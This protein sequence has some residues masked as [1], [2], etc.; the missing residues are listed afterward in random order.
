MI[1]T[2]FYPSVY[3][4][5]L[6]ESAP[7]W[8]YLSGITIFGG[9]TLILS[10]L[11]RFQTTKW[12]ATRAI[13]FSMLGMF[14]LV[15]WGHVVWQ[16]VYLHPTVSRVMLL[17][18]VMAT[19]YVLGA[20]V[21]ANRVPE[22]WF[23]GKFDLFFH[24]HQI[25]H[26]FVVVAAYAHYLGVLELLVWRDASGGCAVDAS[27]ASARGVG[28]RDYDTYD[29]NELLCFFQVQIPTLWNDQ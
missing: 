22:K 6:C 21:Y 18:A 1:V 20:A 17:D 27:H 16:K 24:S 10:L 7:R 4:V 3:Y 12:R 14:G 11:N 23:P 13:C 9:I 28:E 5:F 15:P 19:C 26:V 29:V 25:F 2:S 8:L